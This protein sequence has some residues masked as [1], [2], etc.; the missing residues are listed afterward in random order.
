M[1]AAP[2]EAALTER[3]QL[4]RT[5]GTIREMKNAFKPPSAPSSAL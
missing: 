4:I 2:T 1:I 3:A 5:L